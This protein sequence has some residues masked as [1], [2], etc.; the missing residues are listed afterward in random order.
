MT[1]K[2]CKRLYKHF[3]ENDMKKEAEDMA[4]N[5]PEVVEKEVKEKKVSEQKK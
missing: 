1:L 3:L 2:N 5:R 4:Q